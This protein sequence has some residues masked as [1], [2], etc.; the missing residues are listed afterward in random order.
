MK[1][2]GIREQAELLRHLGH[3]TRLAILEELQSGVKCVTDIR[4][5]LKIPQPNIS[6][7]LA[8]LRQ[9]QIVDYY[10]E[11]QQRCYYL[12]RPS[13]VQMLFNFISGDYPEE[14]N[15]DEQVV[16]CCPK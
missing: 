10:E 16:C 2:L 14:T 11:G 9:H 7:H 5:L 3:P 12:K 1:N 6:Q 8:I 4:T 15:N 13:L